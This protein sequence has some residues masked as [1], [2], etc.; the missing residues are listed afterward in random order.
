MMHLN[1]AIE[2]PNLNNCRAL[3]NTFLLQ[4]MNYESTDDDD[5][6]IVVHDFP[7]KSFH[8]RFVQ[9]EAHCNGLICLASGCDHIFLWNPATKRSKKL[10]QSPVIVLLDRFTKD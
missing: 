6:A 4:S 9:I 1:R 5:D 7:P 10:P 3:L 2:D 8:D